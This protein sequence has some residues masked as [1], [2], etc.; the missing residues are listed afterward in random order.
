M[1]CRLAEWR[2]R[3]L[4]KLE[5]VYLWVDGVYVKAGLENEKAAILVVLAALSDGR[6][7]AITAA[8][9]Y[10]ESTEG[11]SEV[12]RDLNR[13]VP[14]CSRIHL[15]FA[16]PTSGAIVVGQAINPRMTPEV[17]LYEYDRKTEPPYQPVFCLS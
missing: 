1:A 6:K 7:V 10:R 3:P 16:G 15:F 5:V 9:G 12:L 13:L 17:C 11:W 4:D 8:P 2:Q 14:E